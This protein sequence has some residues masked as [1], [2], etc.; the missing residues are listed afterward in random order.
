MTI[1]QQL[2]QLAQHLG[3]ADLGFFRTDHPGSGGLGYGIT[4]V[5]RLSDAVVEEITD[6]PTHSYF[7]HYRTVN[8]Y[9]DRCMLEVGLLLQRQGWR[10]LPVGASQSIP[11]P[12]DPNGFHGRFPHKQGACLAALGVMGKNGLFLHRKYGP[13]VRLGTV[14]TDCP[15]VEENP[16]E[17]ENRLCEKCGRCVSA[18]PAHAIKGVVYRRGMPEFS[19]IDPRLCS[20]YMKRAFQK[21]GRGAVCGICMRVCP[22][23]TERRAAEDPSPR[24]TAEE[25]EEKEKEELRRILEAFAGS[26]WELLA[27]PA[28]EW[29]AGTV[30]PRKLRDAVAAAQDQCGGCGCALDPLYP[31]ALTLLEEIWGEKD[32]K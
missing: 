2:I 6:R 24:E 1:Q 28:R 21:I 9:L 18:C 14:F 23:G 19:L 10:Y 29:L 5:A 15:L 30:A 12:E 16:E 26:G 31:R 4:L 7:H 17:L 25:G 22:Y 20:E 3:L 11:T 8:A 32:K 13:R 27:D